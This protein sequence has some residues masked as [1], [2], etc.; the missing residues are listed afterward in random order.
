VSE[1]FPHSFFVV[2][3]DV[4]AQSDDW[5]HDELD[6]ASLQGSAIISQFFSFPFLCLGIMIVV[7]PKLL[8]HLIEVDLEFLSID[9]SESC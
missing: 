8:D 1:H 7:T 5:L 6:E 9:S 3:H 4:S 2:F